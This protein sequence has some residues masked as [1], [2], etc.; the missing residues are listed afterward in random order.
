MHSCTYLGH[1]V[2]NGEVKP[3]TAKIEAVRTFPQPTTT[4]QARAFIG[5]T[6]Y[7]RKFIPGF[8]S[9]ASPVTNL[10][11]QNSLNLVIWTDACQQ[12]FESLKDS[13]CDLPILHSP[14]F[15][16]QFVLQT[17]ASDRGVGAVL[18]Q[19]DDDSNDHPVLFYSRKLL[20]REEKY[21]TV[22]NQCLTIKLAIETFKVYLL[23]R[24]FTMQTDH[25]AFEWLSRVSDKNACL[26]RWSLALQPYDY[27]IVYRK[28]Q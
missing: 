19:R 17:D 10:T 15:T 24:H 5:L 23:G 12:A 16:K 20:P 7:Y 26:T 25:R 21:A 1:I 27:S 3:E 22:E 11:H 2:G 6:G 9:T 14:D 8:A 4:K 18:S 28:D 13:L